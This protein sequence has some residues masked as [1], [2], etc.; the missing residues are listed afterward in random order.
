MA[1]DKKITALTAATTPASADLLVIVTNTGTTPTTKGITYAIA[2]GYVGATPG[3]RLTLTSA[4]PVTTSDV[5]T[6]TNVY[7][8]PYV[9]DKITLW[10]GSAW[11]VATFT[12]QTLALGTVT[13][14][15]PY[16]VFGYLSSN[17]LA[18]E[19]LAWTSGTA[20]ATGISLQD[21]R[22]CKTGDKTR[23]YLGTFYT[24][25]TTQT[26]DQSSTRYLWN[27]Y[28]RVP[29]TQFC[30]DTTN[31]WNYSTTAW[32]AANASTTNGVARYSFV[33]G[34]AD[35][36]V[37]ATNYSAAFNSTATYRNVG[38]S[39]GLDT[40][41]ATSATVMGGFN[42][43]SS[44][45]GVGT[46]LYKGYP[47]VGFHYL[48]RIEYGAGADTQ[49]WIGDAGTVIFQTGMTGSVLG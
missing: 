29:R 13:A 43:N 26:S 16:D 25:S 4:T 46:S 39:I 30:T 41:T 7:Y 42:C 33:I 20:R 11:T 8:T 22:Y 6:S 47:A 10:S 17:V 23:L 37:E 34:V 1:V 44:L 27:M 5:T 12:E 35:A 49:S 9:S 48:S 36:L 15:L 2:A 45:T 31:S 28:N 21:G 32:Q 24:S 14:S 38:G 19:K 40:T 18:I 3:G